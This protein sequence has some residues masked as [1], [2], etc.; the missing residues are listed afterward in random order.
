MI[1]SFTWVGYRLQNQSFFFFFGLFDEPFVQFHWWVILVDGSK[2][3]L[4]CTFLW[5][6]SFCFMYLFFFSLFTIRLWTFSL[7]KWVYCCLS[8]QHLIYIS[9]K[10]ISLSH[11]L[12][13]RLLYF[14]EQALHSSYKLYLQKMRSIKT[15]H[16]PAQFSKTPRP[17]ISFLRH[18]ARSSIS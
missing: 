5:I 1:F 15:T 16:H 9:T 7:S 18:H 13:E 14:G 17:S 12:P 4:F 2:A 8:K 3:S 10:D 11:S 6:N